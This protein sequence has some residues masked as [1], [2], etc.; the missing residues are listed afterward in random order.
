[1]CKQNFI[2][3]QPTC[4]NLTVLKFQFVK[5]FMKLAMVIPFHESFSHSAFVLPHVA[6]NK[7]RRQL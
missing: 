5:Q 1:M 3:Y 2:Q 6:K 4:K 7:K